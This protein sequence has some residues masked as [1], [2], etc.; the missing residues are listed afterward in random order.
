MSTHA[1]ISWNFRSVL[2]TSPLGPPMYSSTTETKGA[3]GIPRGL[4]GV[5]WTSVVEGEDMAK[6]R[7]GREGRCELARS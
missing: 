6:G 7:E 2:S 3:A 5:R 1:L 4:S